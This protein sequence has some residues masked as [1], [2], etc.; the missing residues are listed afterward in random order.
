MNNESFLMLASRK[1]QKRDLSYEQAM[2]CDFTLLTDL[3]RSLQPI[4]G[5]CLKM[6]SLLQLIA[7]I[8]PKNI[9]AWRY[10]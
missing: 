6:G 3:S 5:T 2:P 1:H 10:F 9:A 4:Y 7:A 8:L